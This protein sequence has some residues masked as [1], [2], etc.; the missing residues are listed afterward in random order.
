MNLVNFEGI[1]VVICDGMILGVG[2]LEEVVGWGVYEF[3]IIFKEYVIVLG[4]VEVYV[5]IMVGGMM[6]LFY[7]GFFDC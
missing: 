7:F 5:Y 1:Y 6:F 4:F 2:L 3:D